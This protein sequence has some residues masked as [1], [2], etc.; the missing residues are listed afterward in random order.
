MPKEGVDPLD[1]ELQVIVSHMTWVLG[2]ELGF[3][4]RAANM[5]NYP[6]YLSS[7]QRSLLS[8]DTQTH[9]QTLHFR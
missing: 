4:E 9:Q 6:S 3:P 5:L 8:E 2:T 1:L 7:P